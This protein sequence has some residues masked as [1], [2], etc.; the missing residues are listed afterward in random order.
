M[1]TVSVNSEMTNV[2]GRIS[3]CH[4]P[5]KKPADSPLP[6]AVLGPAAQA[7]RANTPTMARA[8][9]SRLVVMD[10][11]H[12]SCRRAGCAGTAG[13]PDQRVLHPPLDAEQHGA[14]HGLVAHGEETRQP[15]ERPVVGVQPHPGAQDEP[16]G[17]CERP[18]HERPAAVEVDPV[19]GR[20]RQHLPS[21]EGP[22]AEQ[23]ERAARADGPDLPGAGGLVAARAV[24]EDLAHGDVLLLGDETV[25][26][27]PAPPMSL[28]VSP[29]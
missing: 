20:A 12:G 23:D 3:P 1:F 27:R 10:P 9:N 4:R 18:Q 26:A 16:G 2:T 14:L 17:P 19:R 25:A 28:R 13:S 22:G 21:V 5:R 29:P 11:P 6:D 15:P 24:E 7:A 8:R